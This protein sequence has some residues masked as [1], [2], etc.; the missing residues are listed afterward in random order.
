MYTLFK[1]TRLANAAVNYVY[2]GWVQ[3]LA[4]N[5]VGWIY[6]PCYTALHVPLFRSELNTS[7][8]SIEGLACVLGSGTFK[9]VE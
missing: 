9:L 5:P 3:W 7:A 1:K 8:I 6:M 2:H 4:S